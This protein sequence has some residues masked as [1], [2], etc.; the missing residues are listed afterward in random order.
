MGKHITRHILYPAWMLLFILGAGFLLRGPLINSALTNASMLLLVKISA[1]KPV[2]LLCYPY[3]RLEGKAAQGNQAKLWLEEALKWQ[4]DSK[5]IRLHLMEVLSGLGF[6]N[7]A[8]KL[9]VPLTSFPAGR[10]FLLPIGL[11]QDYNYYLI[12]GQQ[13][14][15]AGNWPEAVKDYRLGLAWGW[16]QTSPSDLQGFYFALAGFYKEQASADPAAVRNDYLTGKYLFLGGYKAE[17]LS[18]LEQAI[19][20]VGVGGLSPEEMG[21]AYIDIGQIFEAQGNLAEARLAL[22]QAVNEAPHLREA[23]VHLIQLL[24]TQGETLTA[25]QMETQLAALGPGTILGRQ[26]INY[27]V[28]TPVALPD[29]WT[30]VGY[31]LDEESLES[32]GPLEIL[33]WWQKPDN[34]NVE[35]KAWTQAGPYWLEWRTVT[36]MYPNA[37]FEWGTRSDGLPL[38]QKEGLYGTASRLEVK[39]V[40]RDGMDTHVLFANNN[41]QVTRV[42]LESYLNQIDDTKYYLMAGW[43]WNED[44]NGQ[45]GRSCIWKVE[46]NYYGNT[47]YYIGNDPHEPTNNWV[48]IADLNIAVPDQISGNNCS[49]LLMNYGTK[50]RAAWDDILW[51]PISSP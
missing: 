28:L 47:Y 1:C 41:A 42:A 31:D 2:G 34:V 8:A 45:I 12:T 32:G 37:G 22:E 43:I 30:L 19:A 51:I 15:M 23:Y 20:K 11:P 26:A 39:Q 36:N 25:G 44:R 7:E 29:G 48:H 16:D 17:A 18:W 3:Q 5:T 50:S 4:P 27:Q 35:G 24:Y 9:S 21:R 6:H 10:S 33:L 40:L 14:A 49:I 13:M 38:G 46:T